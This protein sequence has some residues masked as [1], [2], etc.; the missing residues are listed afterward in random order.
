MANNNDKWLKEVQF[1]FPVGMLVSVVTSNPSRYGGISGKVLGYDAGD[2]TTGPM[3]IVRLDSGVWAGFHDDEIVP[4]PSRSVTLTVKRMSLHLDST[5]EVSLRVEQQSGRKVI[6]AADE[7][8]SVKVLLS[9]PN[10]IAG[11]LG[12]ELLKEEEG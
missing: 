2:S 7:N 12:T 11:S 9:I 6:V 5:V 3:I 10:G 1:R 8:G 4:M